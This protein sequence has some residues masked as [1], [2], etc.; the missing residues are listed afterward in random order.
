MLIKVKNFILFR[1]LKLHV[2]SVQQVII[3]M[4]L[5]ILFPLQ[6]TTHN[7]FSQNTP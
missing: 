1:Q 5:R 4:F 3:E 2:S 6:M 7:V